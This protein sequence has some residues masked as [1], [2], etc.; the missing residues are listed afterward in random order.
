MMKAALPVAWAA[1][2][3]LWL[4]FAYRLEFLGENTFFEI[5]VAGIIYFIINVVI[6]I[7]I[8]LNHRVNPG[9]SDFTSSAQNKVSPSILVEERKLR[10]PKSD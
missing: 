8:V 7:V 1:G 3:G 9:S 10:K 5:W 4:W 2:Q 6:I